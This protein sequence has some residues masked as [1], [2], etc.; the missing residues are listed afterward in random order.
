[1]FLLRSWT[2]LRESERC[3]FSFK[4]VY[5]YLNWKRTRFGVESFPSCRLMVRSL[6]TLAGW[7]CFFSLLRLANQTW[8][9]TCTKVPCKKNAETLQT[10][11]LML[12]LLWL[13]RCNAI[14]NQRKLKPALVAGQKV[15]GT[16]SWRRTKPLS[17][18][19]FPSPHFLNSR[20]GIFLIFSSP[21]PLE[22]CEKWSGSLHIFPSSRCFSVRPQL[23][24]D[25]RRTDWILPARFPRRR[26]ACG[27]LALHRR[28][29]YETSA[30]L[31]RDSLTSRPLHVRLWLFF[32]VTKRPMLGCDLVESVDDES[33]RGTRS[34]R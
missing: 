12:L 24:P 15:T 33:R 22:M 1:M 9:S 13:F 11:T 5:Q 32:F 29:H 4:F 19:F 17:K 30:G 27:G 16:C 2:G 18:L 25:F 14:G 26:V 23:F 34:E 10:L 3:F 8:G 21:H 7:L 28:G 20:T 6:E 31:R